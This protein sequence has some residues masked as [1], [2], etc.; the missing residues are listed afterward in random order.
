M[1]TPVWAQLVKPA[2]G[3]DQIS[4][5]QRSE[6]CD[7]TSGFGAPVGVN[8]APKLPTPVLVG[9]ICPNAAIVRVRNLRPGATVTLFGETQAPSGSSAGAQIGQA[10]AWATDCDFA[11][12]PNWS[13]HP[14]LTTNP[15]K[16]FLTA[17]QTNC[18]RGS[19]TAKHPVDPLPGLVGQPGMV[20][21][22]E[23]AQLI[24][25]HTLTPGAVIVVH[26]D[27]ADWPILTPPV[28]VTAQN[29]PIGLYRKLRA[30]EKV[31]IKQTGCNAAG[32]S[33]QATV[34]PFPGVPAPVIAGPVRIPHG[35]I[36]LKKLIV[37]A[38]VHVFV[39]AVPRTSF[40]ATAQSM[41][42][43]VPGLSREAVVTAKQAMCTKI[44][45]ESN[46][47]V[48]QLGEL[49]VDHSPKPITRTKSTSITVSANDRENDQ[50]IIGNVKIGGAVVGKSGTAFAHT[51]ASGAAP[52]STVDAVDYKTEPINWNLVDP[53]PTPPPTLNMS[54]VN[55]A[56]SFFTITAVTWNI[57]KQEPGGLVPTTAATG[58]SVSVVLTAAGQYHVHATVAVD[59]LVN[60]GNVLAEFRGNVTTG[61]V[62]RHVV[63]W[64][65]ASQTQNFRLFAEP[66]TEFY[67]GTAVTVY[68]PVVAM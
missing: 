19:D 28:F 8:P 49:R 15:G 56:P 57:F 47:E 2:R 62:S 38:R 23:C 24:A 12:P 39:N 27:Q 31:Q 64:S 7:H 51:F 4:A 25:A 61:G 37:G 60:G 18:D 16:L 14:Q 6:Q 22:V 54:I 26:S 68:N 44:S 29:M 45:D 30:N 53:P 13:N 50:P 59:D 33:A 67:S 3:A 63:V 41:F 42:V 36:N 21:P 10:R 52:A 34:D 5:K 65:N 11:L 40:D 66:H 46:P 55:Q 20:K 17:F 43:P 32:D 35:G 48:A 9:P 58:Q 1:G